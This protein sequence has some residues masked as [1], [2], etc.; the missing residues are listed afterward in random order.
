MQAGRRAFHR[1]AFRLS[2]QRSRGAEIMSTFDP[3]R[4]LP[5][6]ARPSWKAQREQFRAALRQRMQDLDIA[7][8]E[9]VGDQV[10]WLELPEARGAETLTDAIVDAMMH[11][12]FHRQAEEALNRHLVMH[13]PHTRLGAEGDQRFS[14]Y[15]PRAELMLG[16]GTWQKMGM[17][18]R[19]AIQHALSAVVGDWRYSAV[20]RA[21]YRDYLEKRLQAF[22]NDTE[23]L[24]AVER[25]DFGYH[26]TD[27]ET[28]AS[29]RARGPLRASDQ[30]RVQEAD[31]RDRMEW[32]G[33]G[34]DRGDDDAD[35]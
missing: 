16:S 33:R 34:I 18:R 28:D 6:E 11:R 26:G 7:E 35:A 32:E 19:E 5:L 2:E 30:E 17:A 29:W 8:R 20:E 14:F 25:R 27:D 24:D 4:D 31:E 3:E 12:S 9:F 13:A 21:V 22:Q 15:H 23:T 10:E 1:P